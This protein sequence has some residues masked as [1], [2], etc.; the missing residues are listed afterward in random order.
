M[1]A[2]QLPL[3]ETWNDVIEILPELQRFGLN[4]Y[5]PI[6]GAVAF[7]PFQTTAPFIY[8]FQGSFYEENGMGTTIDNEHALQG[9]QFMADLNTLYSL[10]LQVP[11]FYNHFRYSTLPI[12]VSDFGTYVQL[13][14]AAPEISGWWDIA[15]HPG[16]EQ[17]DGSISRWASGSGQSA[18]IFNGSENQQEA[19]EVLKWWMSE[20][21]RKL[22]MQERCK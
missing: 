16:V 5:T 2:L 14:A 17:E 9:I 6:A 21:K 22:T 3:P 8:Q 12:G 18:M 10:P 11:N 7:K 20:K 19:W 13:T 4:F 15:L 1:D